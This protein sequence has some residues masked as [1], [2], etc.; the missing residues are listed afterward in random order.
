MVQPKRFIEFTGSLVAALGSSKAF[1]TEIIADFQ[2]P[3]AN[4][5][6]C[7]PESNHKSNRHLAIGNWQ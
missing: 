4:S 7:H 1:M 2:L 6:S 5:E 3:I